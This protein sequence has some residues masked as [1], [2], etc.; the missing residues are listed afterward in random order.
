MA[1]SN[2]TPEVSYPQVLAQTLDTHSGSVNVVRYN[3]GAKYCLSG[4]SDRSIK[5]WNPSTGKQIKSYDGHGRE[6]LG[7][8]M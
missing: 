8:D 4:S 3:H 5:L 7:L 6:V 2:D 1:P